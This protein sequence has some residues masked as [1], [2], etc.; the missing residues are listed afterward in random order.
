MRKPKHAGLVKVIVDEHEAITSLLQ[1]TALGVTEKAGPQALRALQAIHAARQSGRI[2]G[3][4]AKKLAR[5][6]F[7]AIALGAYA[8]TAEQSASIVA[9]NFERQTVELARLGKGDLLDIEP[10]TMEDFGK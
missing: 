9:A 1:R 10:V 2:D 5:E 7:V 6:A 3:V 8:P 4:S